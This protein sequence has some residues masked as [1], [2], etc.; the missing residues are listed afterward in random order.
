MENRRMGGILCCLVAA[1]LAWGASFVQAQSNYPDRPIEMVIGYA[2]GGPMDFVAAAFKEKVSKI[3]GQPV[4]SVFKPGAGGAIGAA[5]AA[6]AKPDGYTLYLGSN[7]TLVL[8]P[9]TKKDSGYSPEELVPVCNLTSSP[10]L[11]CV[12]DDA[13]YKTLAEFIQAAKAKKMKYATY[14]VN[15]GPHILMEALSKAAGF[16]AIHIPYAGAGPAYVACL[17]GHVDMAIS[18]GTGGM[19][20]P[21]KLRV[22][23]HAG[24]ER[25]E[26]M[27]DI[28]TLKELG[29]PLSLVG[30]FYIWAPR[31]TPKENINKVADAYKKAAEE[32]RD[33]IKKALTNIEQGLNYMNSEEL[34]K[35][36]KAEYR[37]YKRIV[38][39]LGLMAK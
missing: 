34:D 38:E 3:L 21:E 16:K 1:L 29:Y 14:G 32:S 6:R 19:V 15:S 26:L 37:L 28:P 11:L 5:Y 25:F 27:P 20:G 12:K 36:A 7:T 22:L 2:A 17:G 10:N 18:T 9:L 8:I 39:D 13:P 4:L 30:N 23:A 24:T 31:Q 33:E 35:A